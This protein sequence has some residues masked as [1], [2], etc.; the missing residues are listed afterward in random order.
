[1]ADLAE[2]WTAQEA[3][4]QAPE[5]RPGTLATK[6]VQPPFTVLDTRQGSWQER[7]RSW[8]SLGI[9]SELGRG[10]DLLSLSPAEQAR[11]RWA[12]TTATRQAMERQRQ[13]GY[14]YDEQARALRSGE[15]RELEPESGNYRSDYGAYTT[16][17][18]QGASGGTSIFDPVLCELAY[19]WWAP[20]GG[21]ILDPFAGGSVRGIVA[22]MLGHPYTGLDLSA[23]QLEANRAQAELILGPAVQAPRWL[24]GD[25]QDL[26]ELLP[27]GELYDMIFTCPPYHDLEVYSDDPRDISTYTWAEFLTSLG[28]ILHQAA[29]RLRDQRFAVIVVSEIRDEAGY[30]KGLVP[31]TIDLA[32]AAG[33]RL[34]N[35]AILVNAAGSLPLRV[36]KY[37]EASRKLGRAHQNVLC[38]LKGK[39]PRGWSYDRA[40]PPS[41]QLSLELAGDEPAPSAPA[42][43]APPD[44]EPD[45]VLSG[46]EGDD[47]APGPS[48][49]GTPP[50]EAL[51]GLLEEAWAPLIAPEEWD[52]AADISELER[53]DPEAIAA[54]D[55]IDHPDGYVA[56]R[57]TGEVLEYPPDHAPP[58]EVTPVPPP[59]APLVSAASVAGP[60]TCSHEPGFHR[61]SLEE[62]ACRAGMW[63]PGWPSVIP[64]GPPGSGRT[65]SPPQREG[66][67]HGRDRA[68]G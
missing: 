32:E 58:V 40:A 37:M 52:Q 18:E 62:G 53:V 29:Q 12:T 54:G 38:F 51:E 24:H 34:Y 55:T 39:P 31:R 25:S 64:P 10:A 59:T 66:T 42:L 14:R 50:E 6:F 67:A 11:G 48:D 9:T 13:P 20:E 43:A 63:W 27:A 49:T 35:E 15:G 28:S 26:V 23:P 47:A 65:A 17:E 8:L 33:L 7:R 22:A 30:C 44:P 61:G 2:L 57:T 60:P 4:R 45:P 19:R 3:A 16:D 1:M 21:A 68:E 56:D 5:F 36:T 46:A 41:P